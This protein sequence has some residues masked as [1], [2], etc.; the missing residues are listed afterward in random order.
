MFALYFK[1]E[2]YCCGENEHKITEHKPNAW[3]KND[4]EKFKA[5][6]HSIALKTSGSWQPTKDKNAIFVLGD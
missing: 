3:E 2:L 1:W 5:C 6:L 4:S